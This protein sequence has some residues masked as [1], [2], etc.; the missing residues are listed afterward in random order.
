MT[1]ISRATL[2]EAIDAAGRAIEA[3]DPEGAAHGLRTALTY[4]LYK[5]FDDLRGEQKPFDR[6]AFLRAL[7]L[8]ADLASSHPRPG[9]GGLPAAA[10]ETIEAFTA[11]LYGRCWT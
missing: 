10:S 4:G 8:A 11:D 9:K 2:N 5:T 6:A 3:A 1:V 7:R